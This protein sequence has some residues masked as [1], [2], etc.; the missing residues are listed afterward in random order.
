MT[1][2]NKPQPQPRFPDRTP[3][4]PPPPPV[5]EDGPSLPAGPS[6]WR[7]LW[8]WITKGK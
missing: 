6:I 4:P 8:E 3:P 5:P 7:R 1:E 2:E